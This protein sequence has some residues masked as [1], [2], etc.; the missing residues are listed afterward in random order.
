MEYQEY[1][2]QMAQQGY[3]LD[4]EIYRDKKGR[5]KCFNPVFQ[6]LLE[7]QQDGWPLSKREYEMYGC[8][9]M[10]LVRI[11]LNNARFKY[12]DADIRDEC[13]LEAYS[14]AFPVIVRYFRREKG[15]AYAFCFRVIYT[16]MIHVLERKN[17]RG[18]LETNLI[19]RYEDD[20]VD[21]GH[22]VEVPVYN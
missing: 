10:T 9:F 11:V 19:E 2:D 17:A 3:Y 14:E 18:E 6:S 7:R 8:L 16:N 5:P 15:T 21:Y 4:G 12:Q 13:A 20:R 22:K 1:S